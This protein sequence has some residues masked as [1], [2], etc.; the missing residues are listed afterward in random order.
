MAMIY[1]HKDYMVMIM[2]IIMKTMTQPSVHI[3][4]AHL[5]QH[6]CHSSSFIV[7]GIILFIVVG[8]F[9]TRSVTRLAQGSS[10]KSTFVNMM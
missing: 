6:H 3:T 1:T 10:V 9:S 2:L 4:A 8:G 5:Q 7:V